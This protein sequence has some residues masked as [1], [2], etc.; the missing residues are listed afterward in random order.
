VVEEQKRVNYHH[1]V[2]PTA[3]ARAWIPA[4]AGLKLKA[5]AA[6]RGGSKENHCKLLIDG[7]AESRFPATLRLFP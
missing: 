5:K 6:G 3:L 7:S 2:V 1:L 4:F